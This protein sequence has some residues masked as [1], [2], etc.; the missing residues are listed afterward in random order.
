MRQ[1][2]S[3]T[4][5][6]GPIV[7]S[8]SQISLLQ[9]HLPLWANPIS[10]SRE[11]LVEARVPRPN[12][13]AWP[14]VP[15]EVSVSSNNKL[16]AREFLRERWPEFCPQ[17]HINI[18]GYFCLGLSEVPVVNDRQSAENWWTILASHLQIQFVADRTRRWPKDMEWDHGE[19][20]E[21]QAHMEAIAK[22]HGLLDE[23]HAAHRYGQGWLSENL[24]RLAKTG[25]RLVNG[26][27]TCP[28]GCIKR[29][30]PILRR[31]CR[32]RQTVYELVKLERL[33]RVQSS[34]FWNA[35][36]GKACCGQMRDCPLRKE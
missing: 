34:E 14:S 6:C 15:I 12:G 36:E 3:R 22:D 24:P 32:K 25:D 16:Q 5:R 35:C 31:A 20:G 1:A 19:A 21:T 8:N 27:A 33:K 18:G 26:R 13:G 10:G 7:S 11:L 9:R 28:R 4:S 17:R 2:N 29:K 30:H 23:V